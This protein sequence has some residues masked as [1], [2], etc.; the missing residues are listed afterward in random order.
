MGSVPI[1]F[2]KL[3]GISALVEVIGFILWIVTMPLFAD[4]ENDF[5]WLLLTLGFIYYGIMYSRYRNKGARHHHEK[6]TKS[7]M[8]NLRARDVFVT[9]RT[10][11]KNSRMVGANNASV[12][13]NIF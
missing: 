11:L 6:E 12:K 10:A 8:S 1:H 3:F 7:T 2:P 9:R 4:S 13:G 5:S